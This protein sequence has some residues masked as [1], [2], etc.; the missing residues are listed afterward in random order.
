[1]RFSWASGDS[2]ESKSKY[3]RILA[4]QTSGHGQVSAGTSRKYHQHDPKLND[5][6]LAYLEYAE[7]YYGARADGLTQELDNIKAALRPV[8]RLYGRTPAREFGPFALRAVRDTMLKAGLAYTTSNPRINRIWRV[9]RWA[10]SVEMIPGTVNHN[11]QTVELLQRGRS[12]A[13]D[14][15]EIKPVP[16]QHVEKTLP[17]V[18]KPWPRWCPSISF[19]LVVPARLR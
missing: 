15:E 14:P 10:G 1:M 19:P 11:L 2:P 4:E 8:L 16:I 5:V 7:G 12:K 13:W 6:I 17:F 18:L 9:F 3:A